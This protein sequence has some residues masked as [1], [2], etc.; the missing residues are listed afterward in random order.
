GAAA[1]HL[2]ARRATFP[3]PNEATMRSVSQDLR[4]AVRTLRRRPA[5]VLVVVATLALG[6]GAN[7]AI[8]SVVDAVLLHPLPVSHPER[9]VA[10]YEA[11]TDRR[12]H[13]RAS[14]P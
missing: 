11:I 3:T 12:L 9:L 13:D 10:V 14:Y 4:F 2:E 5:F 8:F 6:I 1:E 7:T